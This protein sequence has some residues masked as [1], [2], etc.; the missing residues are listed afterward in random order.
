MTKSEMAKK[1][2]KE[3]QECVQYTV[4]FYGCDICKIRK[5][6]EQERKRDCDRHNTRTS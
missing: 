4:Q 6:K 5:K 2:Y 1:N 3:C